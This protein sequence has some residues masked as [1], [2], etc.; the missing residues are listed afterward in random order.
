MGISL[1]GVFTWRLLHCML[2]TDALRSKIANHI[3]QLFP[4]RDLIIHHKIIRDG[5]VPD[6]NGYFF[7]LAEALCRR[8]LLVPQ[9]QTLSLVSLSCWP[10]Y[11]ASV[12]PTLDC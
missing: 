10:A 2:S 4:S 12:V 3:M 6:G 11:D 9:M 8:T 7:C 5:I 1:Q